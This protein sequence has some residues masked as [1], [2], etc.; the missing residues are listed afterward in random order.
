MNKPLLKTTLALAVVSAMAVN[1][2]A[3]EQQQELTQEQN[4]SVIQGDAVKLERIVIKTA[5]EELQQSAGLSVI[6][7]EALEK[8]PVAN[9]ISEIVRKMPG[10]N[11]TGSTTSGQRGN[12]RQIDL[13]GMGP[14][15]TLILIDGRPVTSRNSVRPG[16]AGEKDSRGDSQWVPASAIERIEVLRGS[17]AARYGSGSMGGVVNIITKSPTENEYSI[18]AHYEQPESK[19]EG[20]DWRTGINMSGPISEK[21]S[22]RTTL[23]YHKSE[24]DDPYINQNYAIGESVAA[25][26]EGVQNIDA[27]QLFEYA[28]DSMNT[29]GIDVSYSE[30][31]N[32]WAGDSQNQ[33]VN[34]NLVNKFAGDTTNEMHR[35]G[36]ALTHKG[37]YDFGKSNSYIEFS[38]TKNN[39]LNEG[40][41]GSGEGQIVNPAEGEEAKW[42]QTT[43]DTLNAKSEWDLYFDRHTLTAGA[44][45]RGEKLNNPLVSAMELPVDFDFGQ[46]VQ[47]KNSRNP[48][49]DAYLVG[50][51]LEDNYQLSPDVFI[52]PGLRLDY[53]SAGGTNLSPSLNASWQFS[54]NWSVKGG[55]SRAFKAPNLYQLDPNYIYYT[56]GNGCPSW[57]PSSERGCHV[58][59][60]PNLKN[61]TSWNKELTFT[62]DDGTG[63]TAGLTYYRNDFDNRV[64]ASYDRVGTIAVNGGANNRSVF[65]WENQGK[66]IIEGVEGF[67]QVPVTDTLKWNTNLTT[68]IRSERKDNGEPL[69]LI[70]KFTVNSSVNWDITDFWNADLSASYYDDIEAPQV[71]VATGN[72]I[73]TA[74]QLNR[75][76]YVLTNLNNKFQVSDQLSLGFGI[77]NL[78]DEKVKREGTGNNAGA[79][80]FNEPGRLYTFDIK[81]D[82]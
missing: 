81:Y 47:D 66:A 31:N 35:Y 37:D 22:Y 72:S 17:A 5:K 55:L 45:F 54:G 11:L 2:Q 65:V 24:G 50:M 12:Q 76:A 9:D 57:V 61:E 68:N 10:V 25:G 78:F 62:F 41:A 52:T 29:V 48:E 69:S 56:G 60:N 1:V 74:K 53:H 21:L 36:L 30:Q 77:K 75:K 33:A 14:D 82:F 15:N 73:E 58:L 67:L 7:K 42:N 20:A 44:E 46:V 79:R 6:S 80:T 8:Q 70:P 13:R 16:R 27:R 34:E 71:A 40:S 59:G 63:L 32:I 43:Y 38:R 3:E 19:Y 28:I 39:R 4:Q 26:R 51:Y 18:N 64:S 49:S 23:G